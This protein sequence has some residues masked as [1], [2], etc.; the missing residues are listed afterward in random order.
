MPGD[1]DENV[2][3]LPK[4]KVKRKKSKEER[5]ADRKVVFW[6]LLIVL[7]ITIFFW[8][9]PK[10]KSIKLGLPSFDQGVVEEDGK[11]KKEWKNYV[12]YSL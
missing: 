1:E 3:N 7:F 8:L 12:E 5:E 9:W 10:I 4:K 6:T 2:G 11:P